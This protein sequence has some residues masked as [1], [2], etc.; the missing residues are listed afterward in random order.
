[1]EYNWYCKDFATGWIKFTDQEKAIE[2]AKETGCIMMW[3]SD[4]HIQHQIVTPKIFGA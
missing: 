1:M 4:I 3:A 2:Y